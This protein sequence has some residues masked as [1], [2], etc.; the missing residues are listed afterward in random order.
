MRRFFFLL[1]FIHYCTIKIFMAKNHYMFFLTKARSRSL[2]LFFATLCLNESILKIKLS[3]KF[4][5]IHKTKQ[6]Q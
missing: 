6:I 5:N 3:L 4:R 2:Y 1:Y